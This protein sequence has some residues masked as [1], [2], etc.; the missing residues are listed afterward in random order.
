MASLISIRN[1]R[2]SLS[3]SLVL[4]LS[5]SLSL[6]LSLSLSRSLSLSLALFVSL[7]LSFSLARSLF[8]SLMP[9]L[10]LSRWQAGADV[11]LKTTNG[12]TPLVPPHTGRRTHLLPESQGQNLA[13]TALYVLYSL[14]S[15]WK[16]TASLALH[17]Y[18]AQV[19]TALAPALSYQPSLCCI[20]PPPALNNVET[21][22]N[23]RR[24]SA[25]APPL[26]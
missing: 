9:S 7:S 16:H 2:F 5:L 25:G 3:R 15:S 22:N 14:N 11:N 12:D 4:A 8:R 13:L 21:K 24:Q 26:S 17:H 18:S 20:S 1:E 6:Y 10:S 19:R 23:K